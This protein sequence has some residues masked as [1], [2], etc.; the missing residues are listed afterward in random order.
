MTHYISYEEARD[1]VSWYFDI[2]GDEGYVVLVRNFSGPGYEILEKQVE[3][4]GVLYGGDNTFVKEEDA[5]RLSKEFD[6]EIDEME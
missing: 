3:R 4:D 2:A 6:I 1:E 5:K